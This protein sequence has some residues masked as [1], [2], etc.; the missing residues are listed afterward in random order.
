MSQEW[1]GS[2][3]SYNDLARSDKLLVHYQHRIVN[4]QEDGDITTYTIDSIPH[5][6]APVV[7]GKEQTVVRSDNVVLEQTFFDQELQ[8]I[9]FMKAF[10]IQQLGGRTLAKRMRMGSLDEPDSWTEVSYESVEFDV[11]IDDRQFTQ[12]ALRGGD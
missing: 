2:D 5:E 4:V 7:W 10:E 8:P 3:F 11:D 6:N 12:F 1:A 9:K